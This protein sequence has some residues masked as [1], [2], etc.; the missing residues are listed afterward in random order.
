MTVRDDEFEIKVE[1]ERTRFG[2]IS[3]YIYWRTLPRTFRQRLFGISGWTLYSW[4]TS[5]REVE[6]FVTT[7]RRNLRNDG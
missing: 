3:Y 7:L 6:E 5:Q 1:K 2:T 4:A